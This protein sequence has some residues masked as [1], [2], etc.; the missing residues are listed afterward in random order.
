M[1]EKK[2]HVSCMV[3]KNTK[4]QVGDLFSFKFQKALKSSEDDKSSGP[5]V[6]SVISSLLLW[7]ASPLV[8]CS[9][10]H[11]CH[12]HPGL[13]PSTASTQH[14][15]QSFGCS[16]T[17]KTNVCRTFSCPL[18]PLKEMPSLKCYPPMGRLSRC[19]QCWISFQQFGWYSAIQI[20]K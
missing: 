19:F 3:V 5:M 18:W 1:E 11:P 16:L 15:W 9:P 12:L 10:H 4:R 6:T 17:N 2:A 7:S 13:P 14:R 20:E 8:L